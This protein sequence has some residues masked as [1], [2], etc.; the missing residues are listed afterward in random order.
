M[1]VRRAVIM[2]TTVM[3][4][5]RTV[6][7]TSMMMARPAG[8]RESDTLPAEETDQTDQTTASVAETSSRTERTQP[9]AL[10][11]F[12][13]PCTMR[14]RRRYPL[15][16]DRFGKV[17]EESRE[18]RY[19]ASRRQEHQL[20]QQ[21]WI[22][23]VGV[24]WI[25]AAGTLPPK[26]DDVVRVVV[27]FVVGTESQPEKWPELLGAAIK[28]AGWSASLTDQ[29]YVLY[30]SWTVGA[31]VAVVAAGYGLLEEP[32]DREA[33]RSVL[34][35][36]V[37]YMN[38]PYF[39]L[40]MLHT[41]NAFGRVLVPPLV[42]QLHS[43]S[44]VVALEHRD[45]VGKDVIRRLNNT[46]EWL[47]QTNTDSFRTVRKMFRLILL[48]VAWL[49]F[50]LAYSDAVERSENWT[51]SS[52]G[53]YMTAALAVGHFAWFFVDMLKPYRD[54]PVDQRFSG[55]GP[56]LQ[57]LVEDYAPPGVVEDDRS[58]PPPADLTS[59]KRGQ[60]WRVINE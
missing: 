57:R 46:I 28:H 25:Q 29:R 40:A 16:R 3:M 55:V 43:V 15:D 13:C 20:L 22:E 42:Q 14:N 24:A 4:V 18:Q 41:V 56:Y 34:T 45:E 48:V 44:T 36:S 7:M 58:L 50:Q 21:R 26:V 23:A 5:V 12:D 30:V 51:T 49:A 52:I 1:N 33:W 39:L 8:G 35:N 38:V 19:R 27:E 31:L 11:C 47:L 59:K 60:G 17:E 9:T 32:E 6:P 10:W 2:A 54:F 53:I 37:V